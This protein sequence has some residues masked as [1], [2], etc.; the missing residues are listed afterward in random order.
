M[1]ALTM[2]QNFQNYLEKKAYA[3]FLVYI[4]SRIYG[5][6]SI[7]KLAKQNSLGPT[8]CIVGIQ[9]RSKD[10]RERCHLVRTLDLYNGF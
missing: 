2:G 5:N 9:N 1:L 8:F 7:A 3:T 4:P 10:Q 6:M